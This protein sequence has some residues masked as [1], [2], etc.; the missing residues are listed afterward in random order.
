MNKDKKNNGT[1][2]EE[3]VPRQPIT[4]RYASYIYAALALCVL[5]VLAVSIISA[6]NTTPNIDISFPDVSVPSVI[7]DTSKPDIPVQNE[8]SGVT[9]DVSEPPVVSTIE[10]CVP[11]EGE[12][13]KQHVVTKLVFSETMQDYRTHSGVDISA[14]IGTKVVAYSDGIVTGI[15]DDPLMGKTVTISHK[16][17]LK[18]V[19]QN[20]STTLPDEITVGAEVKAGDIIGAVGESAIIESADN[21]HLHFEIFLDGKGIDPEKEINAIKNK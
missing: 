17:G 8:Q 19:Y 9:D 5:T 2:E 13:Q 16:E 18:S 7:V 6:A 21:P 15:T 20:L 3:P 1:P 4:M 11:C 12:I 10:F 14:P